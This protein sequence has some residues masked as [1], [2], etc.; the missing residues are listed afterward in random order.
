[1]N[2]NLF[3][4]QNTESCLKEHL[5]SSYHEAIIEISTYLIESFG[6]STRIDYGTGHELSFI[7][8]LCALHKIGALKK[9][10]STAT[11]IILFKKYISLCRKL[12]MIYKME[13]AG[14]QGVWSLDDYQFIPFIWGSSQ[15]IMHPKIA[16]EMFTKEKIVEENANEYLFLSC[17]QYILSV[18]RPLFV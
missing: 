17:I 1:M 11:V 12:Q 10:D 7:M 13:P 2:L 16:P 6:N 9:E 14:S 18:S 4:L 3:I 5:P 8:F 15:L